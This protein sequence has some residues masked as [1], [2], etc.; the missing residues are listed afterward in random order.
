M[1]EP[2][3]AYSAFNQSLAQGQVAANPAPATPLLK[4]EDA[5]ELYYPR[6]GIY[7]GGGSSHS[8]LWFVEVLE[9]LGFC[10]LCFV[11]EARIASGGLEGL[12]VL[13]ISGGDTFAMAAALGPQGAKALK[14]FISSGGLYL[15]SCAGAYLPLRSSKEPLNLFN[16]VPARITNLTRVLPKARELPE[17]FCTAYGCE[18]V[19]HPV[20]EEVRLESGVQMPFAGAREFGA[21]LYGGPGLIESDPK[22]VLAR[23][24][25]FSE[26]T[27]FLVDRKLAA[28]TLIGKAAVLRA[29]LGKGKLYLFGPHF[30]HPGFKE[31][32]RLLADAI[33]WDLPLSKRGAEPGR[34]W[35]RFLREKPARD[36]LRALKR[37][38][39]NCR[40][41][42]V[43]LEDHPARWLIGKKVYEPAKLRV[44]LEA[45]WSRLRAW[46]RL[47]MAAAPKDDGHALADLWQ[48]ISGRLRL[49]KQG[50]DAGSDTL[51]LATGLFRDLNQGAAAFLGLYFD[52]VLPKFRGEKTG[53]LH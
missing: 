14:K 49:L 5:R 50:L 23:Y 48:D 28:R 21:P 22:Q 31:A 36:F 35:S 32:N 43:G 34:T 47:E 52:S 19:F 9:R 17:K 38:I 1:M 53:A 16:L 4:R 46:E 30:E 41:V 25:G 40:I 13:A 37:E 2:F 7:M 18:Y 29:N 42:A 44:Y 3:A 15:G 20:R 26:K 24:C 45:V 10:D 11:D 33:Y 51:D 12:D 39:S 8:W 27:R 6:L